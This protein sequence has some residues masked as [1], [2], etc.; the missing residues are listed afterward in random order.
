VD[1]QI[2]LTQVA[3]PRLHVTN[4]RAR[5]RCEPNP[6]ANRLGVVPCAAQADEER[7]RA[8]PAVIAQEIGVLAVVGNEQVEVAIVVDVTVAARR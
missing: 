3:G 7:I 2:V 5:A 8:I 1:A 6:R 4:L